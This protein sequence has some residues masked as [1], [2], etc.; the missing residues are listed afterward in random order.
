MLKCVHNPQ[1]KIFSFLYVKK[2]QK[3]LASLN[4]RKMALSGVV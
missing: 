4:K 3:E 2:N 1:S